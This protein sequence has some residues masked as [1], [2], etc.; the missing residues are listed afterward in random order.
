M[1]ALGCQTKGI[2]VNLTNRLQDMDERILA[3]KY[4]VEETDNSVKK[5]VRSKK[6]P[7][8]KH[9]GNGGH[10][11][12]TRKEEGKKQTRGTENTFNT[13]IEENFPNIKKGPSQ[14]PGLQI[15]SFN[16]K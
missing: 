6:H 8:T 5:N 7:Y 1:K 11:E 12:K 13:I 4:K 3:V 9:A 2:E 16:Q 10:H 14:G 15:P